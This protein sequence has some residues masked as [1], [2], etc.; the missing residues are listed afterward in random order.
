MNSSRPVGADA[1]PAAPAS[2]PLVSCIMVTADRGALAARA[3]RCFARQTHPHRELVVLDDGREEIG[4]VL[5]AHA[6]GAPVRHVRLDPEAP[7]LTLGALR[8]R[9]LAEA[10]GELV[11]QWDDDDWHHPERLAAQVRALGDGDACVLAGTLVH[12]DSGAWRDHPFT[13]RLAGGVPGTILHRRAGA[14]PYPDVSRAEDTAFRDHYSRRGRLR[15][16]AGS[17]HLFIRCFHGANTWGRGHFLRRLRN[18]PRQLAAYLWWAV[19]RRD[20]FRHPGFRLGE[21][22]RQSRELYLRDSAELGLIG[23]ARSCG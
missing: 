14:P 1:A 8:N 15:T 21:E 17:E 12:V 4:P 18:C 6:G 5:A 3:V 16:L 22:A 20:I 19:L 13:G 11:A 23:P 10:R 2:P 7:R 9:A